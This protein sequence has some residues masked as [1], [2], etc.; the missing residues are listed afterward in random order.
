MKIVLQTT[1]K[2][3]AEITVDV[4]FPLYVR[5]SHDGDHLYET[6]IR[7][8]ESK[9]ASLVRV[10]RLVETDTGF[11]METKVVKSSDIGPYLDEEGEYRRGDAEEY[12]EIVKRV[13]TQL[14]EMS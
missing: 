1:R 9:Y 4:T 11:Q 12:N 7:L 13:R 14:D 6:Y 5:Y 8:S 10:D 2:V 3:K